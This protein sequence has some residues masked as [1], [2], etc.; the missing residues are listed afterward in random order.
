MLLAVLA[1]VAATS[2]DPPVAWLAILGV[3]G[4]VPLV[5]AVLAL[6]AM[7]DRP[8]I[9][10]GGPTRRDVIAAWVGWATIA[11]AGLV[12]WVAVVLAGLGLMLAGA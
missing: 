11:G 3:A 1:G 2:E 10:G 12:L 9:S 7:G 5:A 4:L 6:R 8:A